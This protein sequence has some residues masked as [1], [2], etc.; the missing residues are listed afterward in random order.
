[1][2][3]K[4]LLEGFFLG[5][6][7]G[8]ICLVTCTPIYLPYLLTEKR[9]LSKSLYAV[10][11]ISIGRFFSYA[12]FGAAAGFTGSI[13]S[14]INRSLFTAIAYILLSFY[15]ILSTVRTH[16]KHKSCSIPKYTRF[17]KNAILLG[18]FTGINFCP[19]FL[20]ALSKSVDLGGT[21]SGML[22]FIGFFFGTS[23]FLIPLAFAGLLTKV[24]NMTNLARIASI[25][26]AIWFSYAGG[27]GLYKYFTKTT[28]KMKDNKRVVTAFDKHNNLYII[29][30]QENKKYFI[31][32]QDSIKNFTKKEVKLLFKDDYWAN[33]QDKKVV[34]FI[35]LSLIN[36]ENIEKKLE[37]V[38]YFAVEKGY[39]ISSMIKFLDSYSFKTARQIHWKFENKGE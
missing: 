4:T 34:V 19:A 26:I 39:N 32:L 23:I 35:D 10:F 13:I 18:V 17:T 24:K 8:T 11:Q 30:N 31:A 33:I 20:I 2:L 21:L 1:M 25:L 14:S 5:L 3:M 7:T 37:N 22:L 12:T 9:K 28:Y 38:D 29:T 15:L 16:K 36:K 6:S 27:V